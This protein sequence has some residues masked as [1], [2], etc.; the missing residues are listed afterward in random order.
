MSVLQPIA[1]KDSQVHSINGWAASIASARIVP[2]GAMHPEEQA[3]AP[4]E[5][6]MA[7]IY[8][9]AIAHGTAVLFHAGRDESHDTLRGTPEA[10]KA[11]L[12]GFPT[13]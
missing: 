3:F 10:F 2:F 5:P 11:V 13:P 1:T 12:E 6:R 8:E 7:P 4:D 9:A